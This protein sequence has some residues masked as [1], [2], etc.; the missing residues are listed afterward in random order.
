MNHS[1]TRYEL[2]DVFRSRSE[3]VRALFERFRSMIEERGPATMIVYRDRIGFMVKV[4]FCGASP[5]RDHLEI[6]FWFAERDEDARFSKI[7]T[8]A[9]NVHVHTAKV[10]DMEELDD[11]V[12]AWIERS[13]RVGLREHLR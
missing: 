11:D 4:R 13:Y 10:R 3:H 2:D 12:R 1:C 7:E 9:T 5:K 6:G 8:I